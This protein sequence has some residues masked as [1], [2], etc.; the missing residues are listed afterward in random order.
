MFSPFVG[1]QSVGIPVPHVASGGYITPYPIHPQS[2]IVGM[3]VDNNYYAMQNQLPIYYDQDSG[4]VTNGIVHSTGRNLYVA[5][6]VGF[7]S[8]QVIT[9]S[10]RPSYSSYDN[11]NACE[12]RGSF[13]SDQVTSDDVEFARFAKSN[14]GTIRVTE[15]KVTTY[16]PC[17]RITKSSESRINNIPV[18]IAKKNTYEC[19]FNAN[20]TRVSNVHS[21]EEIRHSSEVNPRM[22][23]SFSIEYGDDYII[24]YKRDT[25]STSTKYF[26]TRGYNVKKIVDGKY[27]KLL[28]IDNRGNIRTIDE[29]QIN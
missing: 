24:Y 13:F 25:H 11:S 19:D 21:S 20:S 3:S 8:G 6:T 9:G 2:R 15:K 18:T 4:T 1:I 16:S 28:L 26:T 27:L 23:N 17:G 29:I 14:G 7:S 5:P 10:M 12:R 22:F